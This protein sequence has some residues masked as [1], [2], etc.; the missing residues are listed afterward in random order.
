M[1]NGVGCW[2]GF[3]SQTLDALHVPLH[4]ACVVI[5]HVPAGVQH[6]PVGRGQGFGEQ[7]VSA[8]C[9]VLG[10]AHATWVFT[11][12]VPAGVQ[13]APVGCQPGSGS[14][15][16]RIVHTPVQAVCGVTVQVP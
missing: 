2:H 7:I 9:Q 1:R 11:E 5:V 14:Q 4:T 15:T 10:A 13:Q 16:P 12:Q 8:P 6:A 3:G